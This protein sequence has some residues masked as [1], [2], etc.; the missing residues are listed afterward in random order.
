MYD[1]KMELEELC[2][3]FFSRLLTYLSCSSGHFFSSL[4]LNKREKEE[5]KSER[6]RTCN[7]HSFISLAV[8]VRTYLPIIIIAKQEKR[9]ERKKS[10]S[11]IIIT[12]LRS[13]FLYPIHIQSN[14]SSLSLLVVVQ[15]IYKFIS[16]RIE[17]K[18]TYIRMLNF[19]L[20]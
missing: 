15:F 13:L 3:H 8:R 17:K 16:I 5:R 7:G 12:L 4:S 20:T 10:V 11:I 9:R 6:E 2:V 18:K 14:W 1:F 19:N